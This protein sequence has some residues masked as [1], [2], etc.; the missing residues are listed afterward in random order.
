MLRI[1]F[2]R[3]ALF[4]W[5]GIGLMAAGA[6]IPEGY[7]IGVVLV[8]I[9][10]NVAFY[11]LRDF[12]RNFTWGDLTRPMLNLCGLVFPFGLALIAAATLFEPLNRWLALL[13]AGLYL[14]LFAVWTAPQPL[15]WP[16]RVSAAVASVVMVLGG[17]FAHMGWQDWQVAVESRGE[18]QEITLDELRANGFGQNRYLRLTDFRFCNASAGG[19]AGKDTGIKELWIPIVAVDGQVVK[20]DGQSPPV[21]PRVEVVTSYLD[22]GAAGVGGPRGG[23]V[24]VPDLLRAKREK[25]GFECTVVTGVKKLKPEVRQ[26]LLELAPQTDLAQV[27]VLDFHA[28]APVDRVYGYIAGG[29]AALLL[30]LSALGFVYLRARK[31]VDAIGPLSPV[32]AVNG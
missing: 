20:K 23:V 11:S 32:E 3:A 7:V 25:E 17:V 27:I 13:C 1:V 24:N 15:S 31:V 16:Y 10:A 12:S 5:L 4:P 29:G 26:Q 14:C 21:P 19:K 6:V 28:P 2:S 22:L 30:G 18:P 9:G 8:V